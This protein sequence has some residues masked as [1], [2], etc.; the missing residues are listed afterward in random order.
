MNKKFVIFVGGLR[1]CGKTTILNY[2]KNTKLIKTLE[3]FNLLK[4]I[5]EPGISWEKMETKIG[6][7]IRNL[8]EKY[9]KVMIALHYA[10][11]YESL[12]DDI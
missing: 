11:P 7:S 10:V 8:V 12:I 2:F 9:N 1:G 5:Y 3:F 6:F 4:D